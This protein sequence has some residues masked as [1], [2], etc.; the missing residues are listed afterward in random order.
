MGNCCMRGGTA[1]ENESVL[2]LS[3]QKNAASSNECL[4]LPPLHIQG[5]LI[6]WSASL[7]KIESS[8]SDYSV[9]S[10][11]EF[12]LRNGNIIIIITIIQVYNWFHI[13]VNYRPDSI[14]ISMSCC[15]Q[16]SE[17]DFDKLDEGTIKTALEQVRTSIY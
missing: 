4:S 8:E 10:G 6:S 17:A 11:T 12:V 13:E 9:V 3:H 2:L 15:F 1:T 16:R 5:Y 7:T 14:I